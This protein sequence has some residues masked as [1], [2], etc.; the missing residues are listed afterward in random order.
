MFRFGALF[1]L[2]FGLV[3]GLWIGFNPQLRSEAQ[4]SIQHANAV[5]HKA[6]IQFQNW[7]NG[8]TSPPAANSPEARFPTF[9]W[10]RFTSNLQTIWN[11]VKL[12]LSRLTVHVDMPQ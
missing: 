10:E 4:Q 12:G 6:G 5:F 7:I 8:L 1:L 2:L 3:L 11:W 9:S